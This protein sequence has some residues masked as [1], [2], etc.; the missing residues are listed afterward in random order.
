MRFRFFLWMVGLETVLAGGI[1]F[2][3]LFL[4]DPDVSGILGKLLFY[5]SLFFLVSGFFTFLLSWIRGRRVDTKDL[6]ERLG[7]SL[8]QGVFLG[9]L[10][11]TLLALQSLGVLLW[12]VALLTGTVFLFLESVFLLVRRR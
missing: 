9:I 4:V 12:W 5:G 6:R 11:I 8:R 7:I 1:F 3:V 2:L 10:T